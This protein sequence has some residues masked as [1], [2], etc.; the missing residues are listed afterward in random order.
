[1]KDTKAPVVM[2]LT[3][4]LGQNPVLTIDFGY[5]VL[6][7]VMQ[8]WTVM[9]ITSMKRAMLDIESKTAIRDVTCQTL[10]TTAS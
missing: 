10:D 7:F 4:M 6:V 5:N 1:V 9:E 3:G 2:P 8:L